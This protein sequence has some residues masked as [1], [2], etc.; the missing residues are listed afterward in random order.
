M[1]LGAGSVIG[2]VANAFGAGA[3][4]GWVSADTRVARAMAEHPTSPPEPD[5]VATIM[6]PAVIAALREPGTL[7]IDARDELSFAAGRLPGAER[8][9]RDIFDTRYR[10]LV[11]KLTEAR[12]IIVH[13]GGAD[14]DEARK[15]AEA[16]RRLGH[17][18]VTL[19]PGGWR[20]WHAAGL[21]EER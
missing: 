14:C 21:P 10:E 7:V 2:L 11:P 16:L 12:R 18:R 19:F 9:S 13:C 20:E 3:S 6:L 1:I 5:A 15:V 4:I 17:S 8:L